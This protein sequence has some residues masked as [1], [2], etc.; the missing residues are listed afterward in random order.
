MSEMIAYC[1][2]DCSKCDAFIATQ[3]GNIAQ[4]EKIAE[5]WSRELNMEFTSEDI[6]CDGCKSDRIS[7]WC[8][9]VCKIRPCAIGN[10]VNTCAHC[11]DYRCEQLDEFLTDEPE[12]RTTL[13]KIRKAGHSTKK[14]ALWFL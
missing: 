5:R 6:T 10:G 3:A 7:A 1:G 14:H 13:D 11:A 9:S 2:L 4:K 8:R 12:A